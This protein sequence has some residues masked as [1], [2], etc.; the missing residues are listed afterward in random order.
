MTTLSAGS[1][2]VRVVPWNEGQSLMLTREGCEF[3]AFLAESGSS[4]L[5]ALGHSSHFWLDECYAPSR[6]S[7]EPISPHTSIYLPRDLGDPWYAFAS[8]YGSGTN[9]PMS[10]LGH[11]RA[12][13]S[14]SQHPAVPPR[15]QTVLQLAH[16]LGALLEPR[17]ERLEDDLSTD[18]YWNSDQGQL[19]VNV[20]DVGEATAAWTTRN[21]ERWHG[22]LSASGATLQLKRFFLAIA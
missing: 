15:I 1:G 7:A 11:V 5:R 12:V 2:A 18:L 10:R 3:S 4:V 9:L 6:A 22:S 8:T 16:L 13:P 17:I 19:L 20:P 21:G 14:S